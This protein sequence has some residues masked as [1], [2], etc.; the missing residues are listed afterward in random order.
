[1]LYDAMLFA[2]MEMMFK[3]RE[4]YVVRMITSRN[5]A[6]FP[7][8][9]FQNLTKPAEVR[10]G[11][12][13][14]EGLR[15]EEGGQGGGGSKQNM[16]EL[17]CCSRSSPEGVGWHAKLAA[18]YRA[19]AWKR[20]GQGGRRQ[21]VPNGVGWGCWIVGVRFRGSVERVGYSSKQ[22]SLRQ[23]CIHDI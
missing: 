19:A 23:G 3:S 20:S 4:Y 21:R 17:F 15:M 16:K 9:L 14:M 12:R 8:L 5:P 6:E 22:Y 13:S 11:Y 1:M 7:S 2:N 18:S 10:Q